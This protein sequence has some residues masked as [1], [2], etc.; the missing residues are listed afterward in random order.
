MI[1]FDVQTLTEF[2][3]ENKNY[4]IGARISKIQQ[5]SRR[6][7]I[8]TLRNN[9][10]N[11]QLYININPQIYHICFINENSA[12]KR[13]LTIPKHPPMFCMLLRKY[14]E[15]SY[16]IKLNQP[17][18]ERILELYFQSNNSLGDNIY[19]CL[20]IELMGKHSNIILYNSDTNIILGCAHNVGAEKSRE[21][22]IYGGI[23]YSY[24]PAQ[25]N[26]ALTNFKSLLTEFDKENFPDINSI[27]DEYYSQLTYENKYKELK[28]KYQTIINNKLKK[29]AKTL[30]EMSKKLYSS[31]NNDNYRLCGDLLM[32]NLHQLKDYLKEVEVYDYENNKNIQISLDK[33]KTLKE[34]AN[35]FYKLYTKSKTA[36]EKLT[37][38]INTNNKQKEYFEQIL[39]SVERSE[40]IDDLNQIAPEIIEDHKQETNKQ[41]KKE[42]PD[43]K[44]IKLENNTQIYI[45]KN[46]RQNDYIISKL[47][48]DEDLWF[49]V[50][51]NAGSHVLLKT[52]NPTNELIL[53]CS[54]L[55]KE[56]SS[57]KDESKIGVIYTKRKYLKKPPGANLGYVT[58]KNEKEIIID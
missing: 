28:A 25:K 46:N 47:A 10:E 51:N 21:R 37:E 44:C 13:L 57:V 33:T 29:I 20:A 8:L 48:S 9:G 45:G 2:I 42:I 31:T 12:K 30:N 34:N 3:K 55:A 35:K 16:I 38:L 7:F 32:A 36:K 49:H 23:P 56:N 39:Y 43:I 52:Q 14:L 22:E 40:N 41:N 19:P 58:Y 50:H 4:L 6:E 53:Y 54:K 18:D 11:K 27:I 26:F 5:P 15:S 24:P 17:K 1:S